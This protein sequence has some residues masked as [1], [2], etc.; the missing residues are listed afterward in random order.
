MPQQD[1][2]LW[3]VWIQMSPSPLWASADSCLV[4]PCLV[5]W[6]ATLCM[7]CL[8]FFIWLKGT[9]MKIVWVLSLCSSHFS[10]YIFYKFKIPHVPW[11]PIS[12]SSIQCDHYVLPGFPQSTVL[13][14]TL[15]IFLCFC[16]VSAFLEKRHLNY[17]MIEWHTYLESLRLH[18]RDLKKVS[19]PIETICLCSKNNKTQWHLY[20]FHGDEGKL[21][22]SPP[23]SRE[24]LF[25]FRVRS[26]LLSLK[27]WIH[28]CANS[29]YL[30]SKFHN[31]RISLL[32]YKYMPV[33]AGSSVI[34]YGLRGG[35]ADIKCSIQK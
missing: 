26:L 27:S 8:V 28:G 33:I 20:I 32:W 7:H 5:L 23:L 21:K 16:M 3:L 29:C 25:T 15:F 35:G 11:I 9:L 13:E 19:S 34:S 30:R 10:G 31:F 18:S 17:K 22:I 6:S 12:L 14:N 4:V 2:S 1:S 24:N